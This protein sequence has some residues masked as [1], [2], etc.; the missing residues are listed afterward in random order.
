MVAIWYVDTIINCCKF[1][2]GR[3]ADSQHINN[4]FFHVFSGIP[5]FAKNGSAIIIITDEM[6]DNMSNIAQFP[7]ILVLDIFLFIWTPYM[8]IGFEK[9]GMYIFVNHPESWA[10]SFPTEC[11]CPRMKDT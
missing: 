1:I 7:I 3:I 6:V 10:I 8:L 2:I 11:F 4:H 5:L 9:I